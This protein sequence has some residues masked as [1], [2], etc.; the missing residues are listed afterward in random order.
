MTDASITNPSKPV[1][2]VAEPQLFVGDIRAS[3]D[4]YREKLGFH[5][6]FAYGEPPFTPRSS[7]TPRG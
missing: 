6:R 1:L 5:V 4:F 3:C 7:A 2:G